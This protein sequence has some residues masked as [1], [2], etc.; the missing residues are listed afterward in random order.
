[1]RSA[2]GASFGAKK[3]IKPATRTRSHKKSHLNFHKSDP[4]KATKEREKT[5]FLLSQQNAKSC[6]HLMTKIKSIFTAKFLK[7]PL[8][9]AGGGI[10]KYI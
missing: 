4:Q 8:H 10:Y 6:P 3:I 7:K 5:A 1:M 2:F 9:G